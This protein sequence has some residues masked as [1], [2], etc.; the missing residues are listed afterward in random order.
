MIDE[1]KRDETLDYLKILKSLLEIPFPIGKNL[2]S[3]FVRVIIIINL[4]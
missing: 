4:L 2:L 3:D 1:I